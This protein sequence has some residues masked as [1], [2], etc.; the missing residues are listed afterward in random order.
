MWSK[1]DPTNYYYIGRKNRFN[2]FLVFTKSK[3]PVEKYI[4]DCPETRNI[5]WIKRY[6]KKVLLS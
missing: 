5:F 2:L 4:P 1:Y 6:P 3:V